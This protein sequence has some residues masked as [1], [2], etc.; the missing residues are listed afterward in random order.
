MAERHQLNRRRIMKDFVIKELSAVDRPAQGHALAVLM[1]REEPAAKD[2]G[3]PEVAALARVQPEIEAMDFNEVLAGDQA[4]EAAYRVKDCV[5]GKWNA[6]QRSFETIAGDDDV[7]PAD[8][9]AQMQASLSQFL[10]AVRAESETIAE[11]ITKSLSAV[12]ALA[13]LLPQTGSEGGYPMTDAEKKQLDELKKSVA[14]LTAKLEAATAKEPAKKAAELAAELEK[15]QAQITELTAK[16]EADK[17]AA[18]EAV[19]KAGMSDA[20]KEHAAGLSGAEKMKF[21]TASPADRKKQMSKAADDNPVVYK[22]ERTGEEFRK[23]DDPRLVKYA[24]Q[25]D[26]DAAIA[27]AEREKRE[28][29]ELSKRADDELKHFSE[30]VAKRADKIEVLRAISKMAEGPRAALE[31]MLA[32]GGKAISAAFNQIGHSHEAAAK[33]ADDFNKRV[34]EI[35]ARDKCTKLAALEKAQREFPDEFA[36]YQASG[37]QA[38]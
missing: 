20:E 16:A 3:M 31:K 38:N 9:V 29:S 2:Y 15:A 17:A 23:A 28:T 30:D 13:E 26:E 32:V 14:D 27:K 34:T 25:S 6:L 22:S 8:K 19:A 10:D 36:A 35:V 7:S 12:P 21:M 11:E 33:S 18:A 5:W 24:K 1:K 37:A 4:R